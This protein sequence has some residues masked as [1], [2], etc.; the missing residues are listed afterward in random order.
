VKTRLHRLALLPALAIAVACG[1]EKRPPQNVMS[2]EKFIA[3]NV[4]LRTVPDTVPDPAAT[5]L[6]R[7]GQQ[8]VTP[9]QL[10][11]FVDA[12]ENDLA[13]MAALWDTIARQVEMQN[14]VMERETAARRG[15]RVVPVDTG[16]RPL[17][18]GPGG[19]ADVTEEL[20]RKGRPEPSAGM[21]VPAPPRPEPY[22][23]ELRIRQRTRTPPPRQP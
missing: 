9:E 22:R 12:H 6:A 18:P 15:E 20:G 21:E 19:P 11:A 7:M 5:R 17:P 13:Y 8:E 1:G 4:A 10:Q 14:G 16:G 2:S 3:A 23:D